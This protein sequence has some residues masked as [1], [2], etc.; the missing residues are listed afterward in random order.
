MY[1][2]IKTGDGYWLD[3]T[4]EVLGLKSNVNDISNSGTNATRPRQE[5]VLLLVIENIFNIKLP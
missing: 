3:H 1:G 4:L 2:N 5:S